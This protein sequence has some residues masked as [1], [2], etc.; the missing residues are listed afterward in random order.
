MN[1]RRGGF[2]EMPAHLGITPSEAVLRT[3]LD[4]PADLPVQLNKSTKTVMVF[5][6]SY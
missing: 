3:L 1:N 6:K 2:L 4:A 5:L